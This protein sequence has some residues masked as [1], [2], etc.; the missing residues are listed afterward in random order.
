MK[1]KKR[2]F[3]VI[4]LF[5][6]LG[7]SILLSGCDEKKRELT[8]LVKEWQ[9]R[10][11]LFPSNPEMKLFGKDTV[12]PDL[13]SRDYKIVNYIDTNDCTECR[14]KLF[15]WQLLKEEA[16]SLRLDASFIF[17]AWVKDYK[18]LENL[19][20]INHFDTPILYD[21]TGQADS[22]NHFAK[23]PGFQTFLLDK[24]NRIVLIGNPVSNETLWSLYK[25]TM[26]KK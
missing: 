19:Q 11:I 24:N 21:R 9:G 7:I 23:A 15:D 8:K 13:F 22:L 20:K 3:P 1:N 2:N 10:E 12:C 5:I 16:D 18:Y 6:V 26:R 14:M 4:P 25:K 17:I